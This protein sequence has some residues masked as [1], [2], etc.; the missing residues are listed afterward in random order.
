MV[1][2]LGAALL[3]AFLGGC[4]LL[5][6]CPWCGSSE[7]P[8]VDAYD[9]VDTLFSI[10]PPGS[11]RTVHL[12]GDFAGWDPH[13]FAMHDEDGDGVWTITLRLPR[14][15]HLYKFVVDGDQWMEDPNNPDK[16]DD[17]HGGFNS[18]LTVR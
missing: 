4:A 13:A 1:R 10:D 2:V 16:V 11:P 3:C 7:E 8:A 14:G 15:Q 17:N 5:G 18:V 9:T 12:T 6:G